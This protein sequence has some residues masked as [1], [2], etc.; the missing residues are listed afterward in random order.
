MAKSKSELRKWLDGLAIEAADQTRL[1]DSSIN[2]LYHCLSS[3][4]MWWREAKQ[5]E[6]FLDELYDEF[7]ITTRRKNEENFVRVIRLTWRIDW[8]GSRG[9]SLQKWSKALKE[10]HHEYETN[11]ERYKFNSIDSLILFIRS[12]GGVSGLIK[13][14]TESDWHSP[15]FV[16]TLHSA[17]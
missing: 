7:N 8:D 2:K 15:N 16:D 5:Y 10:I 9:A 1:Y 12:S 3:L 17:I 14:K 4:Y 11:K 13:D 6:G